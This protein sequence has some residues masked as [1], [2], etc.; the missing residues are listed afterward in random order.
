MST[1][2]KAVDV[3]LTAV[4]TAS[5]LAASNA[6]IAKKVA[7]GAAD[8]AEKLLADDHN[9]NNNLKT[10]EAV[11]AERYMYLTS[12]I[13]RVERLMIAINGAVIFLLLGMIGWLMTHSVSFAK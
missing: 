6:E 5:N 1:K 8:V 7:E 11:C 2:T 10:H 13:G 4:V 9:A 3:A 12:R